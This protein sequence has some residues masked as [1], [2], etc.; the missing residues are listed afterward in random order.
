LYCYAAP[1]SL[2]GRDITYPAPVRNAEADFTRKA[3]AVDPTDARNAK[4]RIAIGVSDR[5]ALPRYNTSHY[6]D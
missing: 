1:R 5:I 4:S 3:A 2:T 6:A